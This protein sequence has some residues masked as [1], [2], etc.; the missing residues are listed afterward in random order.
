MT[1]PRLLGWM[2]IL[3]M[4]EEANK[5]QDPAKRYEKYADAQACWW[6]AL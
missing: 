4:L 3:K 2:S 5:E 1:R 6:I